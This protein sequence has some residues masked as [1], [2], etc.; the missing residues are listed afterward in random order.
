ML[1]ANKSETKL[2]AV[3]SLTTS[4]VHQIAVQNVPAQV[5]VQVILPASTLD[6]LTHALGLVELTR[7]VIRSTTFQFV[8]VNLAM[9]EILSLIAILN[10]LNVSMTFSQNL[11]TPEYAEIITNLCVVAPRV[12]QAEI[13]DPCNPSPCGPNA[14]CRNRN[15]VGACECEPDYF[16]NA[17][18]GCRPECTV[19]GKWLL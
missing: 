5:T 13:T 11:E 6:V 19:S 16:G 15:G 14:I 2:L 17:Y 8:P 12:V 1:S 9:K 3:A 4:E 18:E 7:S 10:L